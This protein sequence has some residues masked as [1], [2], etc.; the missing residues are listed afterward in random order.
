MAMEHMV[1]WFKNWQTKPNFGRA[2][3]HI[4]VCCAIQNM[5]GIQATLA[6]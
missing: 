2:V 5:L 1:K 4:F 3:A 6:I